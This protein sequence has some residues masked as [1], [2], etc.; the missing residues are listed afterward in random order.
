MICKSF[1]FNLTQHWLLDRW[2][3]PVA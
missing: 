3:C 1:D 2:R